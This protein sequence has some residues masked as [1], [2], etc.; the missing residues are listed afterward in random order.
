MSEV[1]CL[2]RACQS[3][4]TPFYYVCW[5]NPSGRHELIFK[6]LNG[7]LDFFFPLFYG[8]TE[9]MYY[10]QCYLALIYKMSSGLQKNVM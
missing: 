8:Y 4:I 10:L 1:N 2:N 9:Q 6:N 3:G 5:A 7:W